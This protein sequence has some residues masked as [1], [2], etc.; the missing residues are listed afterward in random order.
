MLIID[1]LF[2][3]I[4]LSLWGL[5]SK[6][7]LS[8]VIAAEITL[9]VVL[10]VV[11]LDFGMLANSFYFVVCAIPQLLG[12]VLLYG[13]ARRLSVIILLFVA[14][15]YNFS[16]FPQYYLH[17]YTILDDLYEIVMTVVSTILIII[18]G[19]SSDGNSRSTP[20]S[21]FYIHRR[22]SRFLSFCVSR[23]DS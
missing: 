7:F 18:Q 19:S 23:G 2:L 13:H 9:A 4:T 17:K 22:I 1:L 21:S 10:R 15:V 5:R 8:S 20:D 3:V 14:M 6:D 12:V 11:M 16:M